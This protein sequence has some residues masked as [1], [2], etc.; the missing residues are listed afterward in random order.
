MMR[1]HT[2]PCVLILNRFSL[3]VFDYLS[4]SG[5]ER[6]T[7]SDRLA[8]NLA[9]W[10]LLTERFRVISLEPFLR[11]DLQLSLM[12]IVGGKTRGMPI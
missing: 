4:V 9:M 5:T 3:E 2:V 12:V 10:A 1:A 6:Q 8:A 7:I 11:L